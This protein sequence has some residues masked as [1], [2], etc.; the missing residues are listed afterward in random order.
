MR[1]EDVTA[2][3]RTRRVKDEIVAGAAGDIAIAVKNEALG[4][5]VHRRGAYPDKRDCATG[6]NL[7][8]S[9]VPGA[10]VNIDP[11]LI[12]DLRLERATID[13]EGI[14]GHVEVE[15][16]ASIGLE[17]VAHIIDCNDTV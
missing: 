8:L 5:G 7:K 12:G 9:R 2:R 1:S 13:V 6:R 4:D 3:G 10:G 14:D 15:N 16:R 11:L 17:F